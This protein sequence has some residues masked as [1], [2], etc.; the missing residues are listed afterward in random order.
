M[1][2]L[3]IAEPEETKEEGG[4]EGF[5]EKLNFQILEQ[6]HKQNYEVQLKFSNPIRDYC[7][8]LSN[9][10]IHLLITLQSTLNQS[11]ESLANLANESELVEKPSKA[12]LKA[13]IKTLR[14]QI[15]GIMKHIRN[16]ISYQQELKFIIQ[17]D[18]NMKTANREI[19]RANYAFDIMNANGFLQ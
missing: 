15:Q 18:Q 3:S 5:S 1:E 11:T 10:L 17:S 4:L 2:Q 7:H 14:S 9:R 16:Q 8:L 6:I 12:D 13:Y 19:C